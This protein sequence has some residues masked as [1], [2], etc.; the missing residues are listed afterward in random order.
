MDEYVAMFELTASDLNSRI[1]GCADGP[2]SFNAEMHL[3]G[4][5]VVSIDPIYKFS[6][7][8]IQNRIDIAFPTVMEQLRQNLD[9]YVW[10]NISSPEE[11][12]EIRLKAMDRF[13]KDLDTGKKEGRYLAHSLPDLPFKDQTFDLALCSHFLFLYSKQFAT[14]FHRDSIYE[15]LRVAKEVR[16]FPLLTLEGSPSHHLKAI[17]EDLSKSGISYEIK[18]VNYEFQRGGN[19]MLKIRHN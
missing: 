11:L 3:Q 10:T 13:L 15:M 1:I 18:K 7:E 4:R 8:A 14:E 5:T 16:I 17:C 19:Q 12:G 9:D 6:V 2:A